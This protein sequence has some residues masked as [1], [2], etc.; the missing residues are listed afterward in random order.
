MAINSVVLVGRLTKD[1]ELRKTQSGNSVVSFTLAVGRN[2]KQPGQPE[3]DFIQCQAWNKTAELMHQYLHKGSL[4]GISGRIQTSNYTD[5]EGKKVYTTGIIV[6]NV[7]F[8]DSKEDRQPD[9][10][11]GWNPKGAY[12]AQETYS[13]NYDEDYSQLDIS[14]D[15]LPF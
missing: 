4:V 5:K 10:G 15:D 8:L 3:A 1:V 7:Q 11:N 14:N 13:T 2:S 12:K 6:N 9:A